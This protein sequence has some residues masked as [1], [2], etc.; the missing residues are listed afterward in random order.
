MNLILLGAPGAGKGTQAEVICDT[1]KI[2]AISTGN[3][4]R[5]AVKNGTEL[6]LKAKEYMESGNLVPDEVVIGLLKERIAQDDCKNGY[7]LD[8]FP[9]TVP[10]AEA[11]DVMGVVIDKVID[12][13][14]ADEAIQKRLSGR[15]VCED[16]G[17]SYHVDYKPSAVEGKCDKCG[18]KTV[19]RKD[20]HPDT[21]KDRLNVYH[22][23]TEPLKDYYSKTGK[24]VIVEGQEDVKDTTALTLKAVEA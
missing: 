13:E 21:I 16:C 2:P 10:Q 8:G 5:E 6:G 19:Q 15:R 22:E 7:V 14:V 24:L 12:I 23:Q 11:L 4:L 1:L 9:R 20:D 3:I 17:A 18:G